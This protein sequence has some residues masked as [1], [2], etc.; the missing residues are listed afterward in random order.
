MPPHII[1]TLLLP[2]MKPNNFTTPIEYKILTSVLESSGV[3]IVFLITD[4]LINNY[5]YILI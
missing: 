2:N 5:H 1:L 4:T 3:F